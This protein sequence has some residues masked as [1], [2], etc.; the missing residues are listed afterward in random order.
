MN[1]QYSR[2]EVFS[3]HTCLELK[4]FWEQEIGKQSRCREREEARR[5]RSAL[6]RLRAEWK[7]RLEKRTQMMDAAGDPGKPADASA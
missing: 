1:S 3:L 5:G 6:R 4:T 7:S 2:P